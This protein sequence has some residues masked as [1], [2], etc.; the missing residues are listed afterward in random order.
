MTVVF[1]A[2]AGLEIGA[3]HVMRCAALAEDL[4]D[5][6]HDILF[7]CRRMEGDLIEHLRTVRHFDVI[8]LPADTVTVEGDATETVSALGAH[9]L[10]YAP[11]W[12]VVDHYQLDARWERAVRTMCPSLLVIDDLANRPH[13]CRALLDQNDLSP[14]GRYSAL[15]PGSCVQLLGP[16]FALIRREIREAR[17]A[18][19]DRGEP[20]RRL[21]VFFAGA[22]AT[23]ETAKALTAIRTFTRFAIDVVVSRMYG[24]VSSLRTVLAAFPT[25]RLFVEPTDLPAILAQADLCVGGGGSTTWERCYLGVPSIVVAVAVNQLAAATQAARSGAVVLLGNAGEVESEAIRSAVARL[26]DDGDLRRRMAQNAMQLVDGHGAA[27]V[28]DVMAA[29][30]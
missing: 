16:R 9:A 23:D 19:R 15:V 30:A 7:V 14:V 4:R 10:R 2:D 5:A 21:L 12:I 3:G 6:G 13:D 17:H 20:V 25:A 22:D 27:R 8:A 11:R 26:V 24:H 28:I 18:D 1:R 29:A